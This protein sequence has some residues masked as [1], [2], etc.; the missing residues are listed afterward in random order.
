MTVRTVRRTV[1]APNGHGRRRAWWR[2]RKNSLTLL[3]LS[4]VTARAQFCIPSFLVWLEYNAAF[5]VVAPPATLVLETAARGVAV[6]CAFL[7]IFISTL[8]VCRLCSLFLAL[9]TPP[10]VIITISVNWTP[11]A[12]PTQCPATAIFFLSVCGTLPVLSECR[13][14]SQVLALLALLSSFLPQRLISLPFSCTFSQILLFAALALVCS[15]VQSQLKR[16]RL[17]ALRA[18]LVQLR[19]AAHAAHV[20]ASGRQRK[21]AGLVW[22]AVA[23]IHFNSSFLPVLKL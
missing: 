7:A 1:E 3:L 6:H 11:F 23:H 2:V 5:I 10:L 15:R 4:A 14:Q 12:L 19:F 22:L 8:F 20:A 17:A 9:V 21:V 18:S 16:F 13:R